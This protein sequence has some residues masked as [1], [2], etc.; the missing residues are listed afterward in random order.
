[1]RGEFNGVQA[2]M[3]EKIPHA[4]Y[5]HCYAHKLNLVLVKSIKDTSGYKQLF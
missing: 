2:L 3:R 1:M 5:V 4:I